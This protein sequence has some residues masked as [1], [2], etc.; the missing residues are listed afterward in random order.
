MPKGVLREGIGKRQTKAS[1]APGRSVSG[2]SGLAQVLGAALFIVTLV[3]IL[4]KLKIGAAYTRIMLSGIL[5]AS[6]WTI[7]LRDKRAIRK[8]AG[9]YWEEGIL[10]V[11]DMGPFFVAMGIFSG[12]LESSGLLNIARPFIQ[13]AAIWLGP[14]SAAILPL[15]IIILSIIGLHPFIT[16]VLFGKILMGAGVPL[17]VLT[18][19]LSLAV[20]GAAAYMTSPFAG[21]IMSLSRYT[22]AKASEIAVRWNWKFSLAFFA[23]GI[24]FSLGWGA[25][26][27]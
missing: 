14:F 21:I 23:V 13:G 10:K 12:A 25:A 8:A 15:T 27:G 26:F 1:A 24:A 17:P 9:E 18:I 5:V 7:L 11:R 6:I 20:G 4:E 16:L 3:L 19:A 2:P 22:G